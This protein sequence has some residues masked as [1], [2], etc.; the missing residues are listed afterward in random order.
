M[1]MLY[2]YV[3]LNLQSVDTAMLKNMS[4]ALAGYKYD[5]DSI[6]IN[7]NVAM[8]FL[9]QYITNESI[10]DDLPYY[11]KDNGLYFVCD[12]IIDNRDELIDLLGLN[13]R[14]DL[15]DSRIIFESYKK[16]KKDCTQHLLGDFAFIVYD[17]KLN[18]VQMF[19]DHMGKR[20]I[21]YRIENNK[22]FFSTLIKP[23]LDPF[24]KKSKNSLNEQYLIEFLSIKEIRHE[25][26]LGCTIYKDISYVIPASCLT[27]SNNSV[28]NEVYWDPR[29]IK[30]DHSLKRTNYVEAFKKVFSEAVKCRLRTN[31]EIG[32][33]LSGG[34]DSGSVAC[35]A[36]SLLGE[37][38]EKLN[39]YTSVPITGFTKWA[40]HYNIVDE[41]KLVLKMQASYP[42]MNV[43]IIDSK[44]KDSLNSIER[45]LNIYEQPYKFIGNSYWLDDIF[46]KASN[47]GCKIILSG[48]LGNSTISYGSYKTHL[49]EHL[50][51]LRLISFAKD[52]QAI[53]AHNKLGRKSMLAYL[54]KEFFS[55]WFNLDRGD[56][57][58]ELVKNN[59]R[60][61]YDVEKKMRAF[62]FSNKPILR[63]REERKL[64]FHPTVAHH[65]S[66]ANAKYSVANN[67]CERDPT[68]DKRV[69]EFC[70]SLPYEC[71]FYHDKGLDRGLIRQ[72][73]LG[74]VPSEILDN[75]GYKGLQAA[76]SLE[77]IDKQW[78]DFIRVIKE[79]MQNPNDFMKY[80]DV[81]RLEGLIRTHSKLTYSFDAAINVRS[82]LIIYICNKFHNML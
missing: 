18:Q 78:G 60:L 1:S 58:S 44:G 53:C 31:G 46:Q 5:S 56:F 22:I 2:G 27:V 3:N 30:V 20:L 77:R 12:A 66:S 50:I 17:V 68:G 16:W 43:H 33:F 42:N 19:R 49:F 38:G 80:I 32:I 76:D 64:Y 6:L 8:G 14:R 54:S 34:L 63:V 25:I 65:M 71:Y 51:R 15:S 40:P 61:Q 73:M 11:D 41:S 26:S 62:G 39:T 70:L 81:D 23:L 75:F 28:L 59:Y 48:A 67:I 4:S 9:N 52:F 45:M 29:K 82:I 72:A 37:Q 74:I 69:V 57:S 13:T 7:N 35:V 10:F 47:D 21:Y 36:A 24:G 79:E 55:S